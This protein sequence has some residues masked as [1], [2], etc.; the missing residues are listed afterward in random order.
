MNKRTIL[1]DLDRVL[2]TYTGEFDKDL[3]PPIKKGTKEFLENLKNFD[4]TKLI[5]KCYN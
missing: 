3:I 1:I 4:V 2:N 5:Y